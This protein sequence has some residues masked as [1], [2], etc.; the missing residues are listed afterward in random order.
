MR[1]VGSPLVAYVCRS[2]TAN[3]RNARPAALGLHI[4]LASTAVD[5][6]QA[7]FSAFF[8]DNHRWSA[9]GKE[10]P[11]PP[12][13]VLQ[14]VRGH[15]I[16]AAYSPAVETSVT[17]YKR[18]EALTP[19][20][21][22]K[23]YVQLAKSNLTVLVVLT[24]MAGVALSPLPT[25]VPVLL[26]TALGTALC[27]ASANAF[28]QIQEI[29]YDAQMARTRNRPLVRR[30]ISPLH[31]TAFAVTTGVA[32]PALLCTMVNPTTA[33]LGAA[34]I[35]LY[36]GAYTYLKRK[37]IVNTWVGAVVG[38]IPPLMGWTACGGSLLPSSLQNVE[39]VLPSF[40]SSVT[41]DV[42]AAAE[43]PL[44]PLA[45]FLLLYSWQFPHFN[46]LS[47]LVRESYA[48]AGYRMLCVLDPHKNAT[49]ALRHALLLVP[50][51]SILF[52]LAGLTTWGFALTSI[53]PHAICVDAAYKFWKF[54]GE[55][56]ARKVFQH[57]LWYL[58]V[59]L[60]LMMFHK[61]GMDWGSWIGLGEGGDVDDEA[62]GESEQT[63]VEAAST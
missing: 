34:N 22:A 53:V 39:L 62:A 57:S 28:N 10:A 36:A 23:I 13:P 21:L 30:A 5:R 51:T 54:G 50:A 42:L 27:S 18:A 6:K 55:K 20:R 41:T 31:A 2:C 52:P 12:R 35:A 25:T 46:G 61:R 4:R 59:L 56:Q 47:H 38:G 29:P 24:A 15:S 11:V 14:A 3:L 7:N 1:G 60:G 19:R 49:V 33:L 17:T 26:S 40:L 58:P 45:L 48:Q 44:A 16:D 63:S 37:S 43:N 32:G 9:K 8:F